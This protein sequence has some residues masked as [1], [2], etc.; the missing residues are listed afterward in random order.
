MKPFTLLVLFALFFGVASLDAQV[1]RTLNFQ[2]SFTGPGGAPL[3]GFHQVRVAIFQSQTGGIPLYVEEQSAL[4]ENGV[5]N[6][7]IGLIVPLN[8]SFDRQYYME[9]SIPSQ[10]AVF[11]RNA[12]TTVPTAYKAIGLELPYYDSTAAPGGAFKVKNTASGDALTGYSSG[13]MG[14][15]GGF[16]CGLY[17]ESY[18]GDYGMVG[19]ENFGAKGVCGADTSCKGFLGVYES[20]A[21]GIYGGDISNGITLGC[22]GTPSYGVYGDSGGVPSAWA[23]VAEPLPDSLSGK[24]QG[25]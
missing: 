9:F 5:V 11:P 25:S 4:F 15:A 6:L 12:F 7:V 10:G 24:F 19:G 13:N 3:T 22:L 8:L 23:R 20:G 21:A 18:L 16:D 17:G 14:V 1:P 2:G